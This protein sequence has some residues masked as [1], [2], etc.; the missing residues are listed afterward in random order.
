M[1]PRPV[2]CED[3]EGGRPVRF[4]TGWRYAQPA[5][6]Q[7]ASGKLGTPGFDCP[8]VTPAGP[9][10]SKRDNGPRGCVGPVCLPREHRETASFQCSSPQ[11]LPAGGCKGG[12]VHHD[13]FPFTFPTV[14]LIL[15]RSASIW[16][17]SFTGSTL[18]S[19][20]LI[21]R[22]GT[23]LIPYP[24]FLARA[25][26][27]TS[28]ANLSIFASPNRFLP[29]TPRNNLNPHWVS[30]KPPITIAFTILLNIFPI[31]R[32]HQGCFFMISLKASALDP[33]AI[34][35]PPSERYG[36]SFRSSSIGVDR[37]ASITRIRPPFVPRTPVL[38][39]CPFP[40]FFSYRTN[41]TFR[42]SF[43]M[44]STIRP[45]PSELP[46]STTMISYSMPKPFICA[47]VSN[48]DPAIRFSSLYAGMTMDIISTDSLPSIR[49]N[50][51]R[52]SSPA[53]QTK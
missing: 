4:G 12:P 53:S 51:R 15:T 27:S 32:L 23:S 18:D 29:T 13:P 34:S 25:R 21:H 6:L 5:V 7:L 1:L 46:S 28:Y 2:P 45:V 30:L 33:I 19:G 36:I 8:P 22:I 43:A 40:R 37:S 52:A 39:A 35:N 41:L 44:W 24:F 49:S 11:R 48:K 16:S 10:R 42:T 38:R 17:E 50:H 47:H 31:P 20:E 9:C 3:R 26:I 14:N